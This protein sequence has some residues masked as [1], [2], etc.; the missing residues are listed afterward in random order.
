MKTELDKLIAEAKRK[1][2]KKW[3]NKFAFYG[4][5]AEKLT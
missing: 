5:D 1:Y 4:K 2:D 3:F